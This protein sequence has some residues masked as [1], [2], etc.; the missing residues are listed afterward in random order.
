M[1]TLQ[2]KQL[3]TLVLSMF[4]VKFLQQL[5]WTL[6]VWFVILSLKLVITMQNTALRQ[7][8]LGFTHH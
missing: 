5:M 3:S 4:S 6:T 1:H 8:L 2:Q 7:N